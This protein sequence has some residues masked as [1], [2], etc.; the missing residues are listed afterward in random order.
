MHRC[1]Q[2]EQGESA[3][4]HLGDLHLEESLIIQNTIIVLPVKVSLSPTLLN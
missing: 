3:D 4:V 2:N 1:T